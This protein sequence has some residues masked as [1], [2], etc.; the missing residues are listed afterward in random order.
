[1]AVGER[2]GA[3]LLYSLGILAAFGAASLAPEN[4]A[5][6]I[7]KQAI[8]SPTAATY[9]VV[10]TTGFVAAAGYLGARTLAERSVRT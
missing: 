9:G 3:Q 7:A 4:P 2:R 10:A 6:A 8:G 5:N 1:V